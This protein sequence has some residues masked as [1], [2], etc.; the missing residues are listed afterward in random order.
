MSAATGSV[1][2]GP[3][4]PKSESTPT[5]WPAS[6]S[7]AAVSHTVVVL[8]L[9]PA[10][11]M[12]RI[13]RDGSPASAWQSRAWAQSASPTRQSGRPSVDTI[14]SATT[15]T[16]PRA[17]ATGTSSWPSPRS[18]ARATNTSPGRQRRASSW[19]DR[20]TMSSQPMNRAPPM[21]AESFT[22]RWPFRAD[23]L[24]FPVAESRMTAS[25]RTSFEGGT[26]RAFAG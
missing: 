6:V 17:I 25:C 15:A 18:V 20:A 9:V 24:P 16:A 13:S 8:P 22:S 11:A 23:A 4:Q 26:R 12:T 21:T 10:T 2:S 7:T 3:R 19:Q 14:R 1:S 5:R